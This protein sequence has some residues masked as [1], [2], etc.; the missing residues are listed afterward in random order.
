MNDSFLPYAKQSINQI[1]IKSASRALSS[2]IITR[3]PE[4]ER[5]ERAIAK[6]CGVKYAVAFNSGSTALLAASYAVKTNRHDQLISTPNTF[7]ASVG[8]AM[9]FGATPVFTDID[10]NTGNFDLEC[11]AHALKKR[12]S[13][14]RSII[15]A[16]HFSGIPIEM[17]QLDSLIKDPETM[18]IEDGCHALGSCYSTGE[19]VGSCIHSHITIFSFHPAKTISTGEGGIA[20]TNDEELHHRLKLFRNNGIER[21]AP[22]L[23][24]ETTPWHYEVQELTSNYNFTEFQAAIGQSQLKRIGSFIDKR[25]QLA[26]LYRKKLEDVPHLTMFTQQYDPRS[27]FNLFVVQIDFAKY[28][29]C[30]KNV[31]E[32][33]FA[34]KIGTQVHYIPIY[35]H[36]FFQKRYGDL[37][38]FF[39]QMEAY[40][41]EALSLPLYPDLTTQDVDRVVETLKSV[42][43][44]KS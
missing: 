34:K 1:D 21:E 10:R 33:L 15:M 9:Q 4:V 3:G 29:T 7:V 36:P 16:V 13:R 11:V 30:R 12:R 25:R 27:A 37:S 17:K 24:Q 28:N 38:S 40:Y 14:G 39:P 31:M 8:S 44:K 20:T 22:Y 18:V 43:Y 23:E 42:L 35:R 6:Y 19:R 32:K 41:R 26:A 5:F 2:A